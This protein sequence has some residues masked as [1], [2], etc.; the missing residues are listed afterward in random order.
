MARTARER[1]RVD[2]SHRAIGSRRNVRDKEKT[3]IAPD[4]AAEYE[5]NAP[6][7]GPKVYPESVISVE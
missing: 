3:T 4:K 7:H 6:I 2:C 5:M 1:P